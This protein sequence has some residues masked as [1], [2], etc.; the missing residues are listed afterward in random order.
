MKFI[1]GFL[2]REVQKADNKSIEAALSKVMRE[3]NVPETGTA[4]ADPELK[5][6]FETYDND[7]SVYFVLEKNNLIF[8]GAGISK[9]KDTNQNICELQK[10][11]FLKNA[12]GI[13]LGD[14]MIN[15]CLLKAKEYGFDKCYIETMF[16]MKVAQNLYLKKGFSYI[17]N[18]LGNTGHSSCPIWMIKDLK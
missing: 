17:N 1:K 5:N 3:F 9:L 12:R 2:I 18:P 10:M 15:L 13:G 8:G 16:N 11:Y 14:E 6:I 7:K 4:L